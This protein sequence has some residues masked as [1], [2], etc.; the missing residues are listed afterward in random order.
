MIVLFC[1]VLG[2]RSVGQSSRARFAAAR[3]RRQ[4]GLCRICRTVELRGRSGGRPP[5]LEFAHSGR[6][7]SDHRLVV[8]G[9][10]H[11]TTVLS[12]LQQQ[13][14]EGVRGPRSSGRTTAHREQAAGVGASSAWA[15]SGGWSAAGCGSGVVDGPQ[16]TGS[17]GRQKYPVR[18]LDIGLNLP[19]PA[20]RLEGCSKR[21]VCVV[22]ADCRGQHRVPLG[23]RARLAR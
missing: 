7:R 10:D 18:R 4:F 17:R 8:L 11:G 13:L 2:G 14:A 12:G 3:S 23:G 15:L 21:T 6:G 5:A 16:P 19:M 22:S 1:G 9:E 20:V